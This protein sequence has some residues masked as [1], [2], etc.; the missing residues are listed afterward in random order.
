MYWWHIVRI[1]YNLCIFGNNRVV[2]ASKFH[3][4]FCLWFCKMKV[5][6]SLETFCWGVGGGVVRNKGGRGW[7]LFKERGVRLLV[8]NSLICKMREIF[9][10]VFFPKGYHHGYSFM[11]KPNFFPFLRILSDHEVIELYKCL[12]WSKTCLPKV[13]SLNQTHQI[14]IKYL[15]PNT[16]K[17]TSCLLLSKFRFLHYLTEDLIKLSS[18]IKFIKIEVILLITQV[19][20]SV[21]FLLFYMYFTHCFVHYLRINSADKMSLLFCWVTFIKSLSG[22]NVC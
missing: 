10:F 20:Q 13:H 15:W 18:D 4:T 11:T 14:N 16:T 6:G 21:N 2:N 19:L 22:L 9:H 5:C 8:L 12:V 3:A 1:S 7:G 17:G